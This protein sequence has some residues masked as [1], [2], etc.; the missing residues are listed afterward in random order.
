MRVLVTGA[1]GFIGGHLC[2]L[3]LARGHEV[4]AASRVTG[5]A[6]AGTVER[7]VGDIDDR[8]HWD[9]ALKG[10]DAVVH[11]AA[12]V[13][14]MHDTSNDPLEA[15]R[16]TN[17][18]GTQRLAESAADAG[19]NQ[20]VFLSS[21]KALGERTTDE[22]Y[23]ATTRGRPEDPYGRSKYEAEELLAAVSRETGMAVV[24]IQTPLVF[25]AGVGGNFVSMLSWVDS[26]VPLP[27]SSISNRRSM[28]SV[29][30]LSALVAHCLEV[31]ELGSH[32][33]MAGEDTS[34]STPD[35]LRL[36][37]AGLGRRA[38][39]IPVPSWLLVAAG[40][41]VGRA[42]MVRRLTD[43]LEV[44]Y[45]STNPKWSWTPPESFEVG[46]GHV[47]EWFRRGRAEGGR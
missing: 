8:T 5:R 19:V 33:V 17:T 30:N 28:I 18:R 2:A 38:R 27:L 3:L 25:G 1:S 41:L 43:S 21:V 42:E 31:P 36:I 6:P 46:I 10:V 39:L 23:T 9:Q 34:P 29:R 15:F 40:R 44:R 4:I 24:V 35:L 12:R 32:R 14:V 26:G 16:R 45:G 47:T 20:F 11:L 22:P 13:H 7:V 37:A